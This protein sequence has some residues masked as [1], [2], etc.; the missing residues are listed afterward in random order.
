MLSDREVVAAIGQRLP[1]S[2]CSALL[3]RLLRVPA[4]WGSLH[5]PDLLAQVLGTE[6]IASLQ[7][8]DILTAR[9]RP[10]RMSPEALQQVVDGSSAADPEAD[11]TD[12]LSLLTQAILWSSQY[13]DARAW[14]PRL[15]EDSLWG[16]ALACAWPDLADP[17]LL[18]RLAFG[19]EDT[20]LQKATVNALLANTTLDLAAARM[21]LAIAKNESGLSDRLAQLGEDELAH[22]LVAAEPAGGPLP[23]TIPEAVALAANARLRGEVESGHAALQQA[24]DL[25]QDAAAEV[26]DRLAEFAEGQD[27]LILGLEARQRALAAS[28]TPRRRAALAWCQAQLG[29]LDEALLT[30]G[31]D[32][33][34]FEEQVTCAVALLRAG[35]RDASEQILSELPVDPDKLAEIPWVWLDR[36]RRLAASIGSLRLVGHISEEIARRM[37]ASFEAWL[38]RA[39]FYQHTGQATSAVDAAMLALALRPDA[40]EAEI[41]LAE[42]LVASGEAEKALPLWERLARSESA[43]RL[44]HAQCAL[45]AGQPALASVL[46]DQM[47]ADGQ[48]PVAAAIVRAKAVAAAG[49]PDTARRQLHE[50]VANHPDTPEAWIALAELQSAS[51]ED[52]L[53]GATLAS[54]LQSASTSPL[55]MMAYARWLGDHGRTTEAATHALRAV[56]SDQAP[57]DWLLL[58]GEW[59]Q[60]LGRPGDAIPLLRRAADMLPQDAAIQNALAQALEGSGR[61]LEAYVR[62]RSLPVE[63]QGIDHLL[64]GRIGIEITEHQPDQP[65]LAWAVRHLAAALDRATADPEIDYWYAR[66]QMLSGNPIAASQHYL[67]ATAK[68]PVGTPTHRLAALAL[69]E[70]AIDAGQPTLALDALEA[71]VAAD[72]ICVPA[73]Q[74]LARVYAACE[75]WDKALPLAE[76]AA[77]FAPGDADALRSLGAIAAAAGALHVAH[78]ANERLA[79]LQPADI[80]AWIALNDSA[81]RLER[82]DQQRTALSHALLLARRDPDQLLRISGILASAGEPTLAMLTL[83]RAHSQAP[84]QPAPLLALAQVAGL[85]GDLDQ[86]RLAWS[87]LSDLEPA[88]VEFL[89][90]AGQAEHA[91]GQLRPAVELYRRAASA[92]PDQPRTR[93]ALAR[94]LW[95]AGEHD[96]AEQEYRQ[97]LITFPEDPAVH[98][99]A[100]QALLARGRSTEAL[101]ASEAAVRLAPSDPQA[102]L[103]L[104]ESLLRAGRPADLL[105]L[106]DSPDADALSVIPLACLR[107]LAHL[108]LDEPDAACRAFSQATLPQ[109]PTP[110]DRLWI[111]R[112]A[113]ELG[114]WDHV[115]RP[116]LVAPAAGEETHLEGLLGLLRLADAAWLY[117]FVGAQ[118]HAPS[119]DWIDVRAWD[120]W[121]RT[122]ADL[123]KLPAFLP[124][125]RVLAARADVHRL[126]NDGERRHALHQILAQGPDAGVAETLGIACLRAGLPAE[127]LAGLRAV[128][129]PG[130]AW[131]DLL[132]GMAHAGQ[133]APALALECYHAAAGSPALH[134]LVSIL[135]GR[136]YLQLGQED[137]GLSELA[138]AVAAWP[139]EPAWHAELAAAYAETE[140]PQRALPHLQQAVAL[141]PEVQ[142]YHLAFARA[143]VDAGQAAEAVEQYRPVVESMPRVGSMWKEAGNA[144]LAAGAD[145]LAQSW[146]DQACSL[147]P[148]D[149]QAWVGAALAYHRQGNARRA[150]ELVQTAARLMPDDVNVLMAQGEI[151]AAAGKHDKALQAY[152]AAIQVLDEPLLAHLG[153]VGVMSRIGRGAEAIAE[154]ERLQASYPDDERLWLALSQARVSAGDLP[155]A[156]LAAEKAVEL[157]P[158]MSQARLTLGRLARQQ[159]QLDRAIDVLTTFPPAGAEGAIELGQAYEARREFGRALEQFQRAIAIDPGSA[160]AHFHAGAVLRSIKDYPQASRMFERAVQLDPKDADALHQLAA[161]RT[162]EL[163]HGAIPLQAV[164]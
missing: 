122:H 103:C 5:H 27:E 157:S 16:E 32:P 142:D 37:P 82:Q 118:R 128:S 105:S 41:V 60:Q 86:A 15:H 114:A 48:Q 156:L 74:Q 143:L 34:S 55:L 39:E 91:A 117:A 40:Q 87:K 51:G 149:A 42:A 88:N 3:G 125:L 144:A 150:A 73:L 93:L 119:T 14:W 85:T 31:M 28:A 130:N 116:E 61:R 46:A 4:I 101:A 152:D 84:A 7:P 97:A 160:A 76:Q 53:A 120:A 56:A 67:A 89:L 158:R 129:N 77:S 139:D 20:N 44:Q 107:T 147:L 43:Y 79:A 126:A 95:C 19:A 9:V 136:T 99:A 148:D 52:A 57:A 50:L 102:V 106:L 121:S 100:A 124:E 146:L 109:D 108:E 36:A 2:A 54:A 151:F 140:D 65:A 33:A 26:A 49:D 132:Q 45:L 58:A 13:G 70:A 62:L 6:S 30:L 69:A 133:G 155:G 35:E 25:A 154:I 64:A 111:S 29:Q 131:I 137:T 18:L 22:A 135:R 112:A 47:Q 141:A 98:V 104:A 17:D 24:W 63:A 81:A 90:A 162:L 68:A 11:R 92:A 78:Q 110:I 145:S 134:P 113:R 83:R 96:A 94:E 115:L 159:G 8:M 21:R 80:D 12:R 161:V 153:R 163:V 59:I 138:G 72:P 10:Q 66:G 123:S 23:K 127:A 71:L 1:A 38:H 164:L 75:M